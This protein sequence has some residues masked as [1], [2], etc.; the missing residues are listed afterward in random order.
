M[1]KGRVAARKRSSL[2]PAAMVVLMV[3]IVVGKVP[4]PV[5]RFV[6]LDA[7]MYHTLAA[8]LVASKSPRLHYALREALDQD[9]KLTQANM[10]KVWPAYYDALPNGFSIPVPGAADRALERQRLIDL[11]GGSAAGT[12][13]PS[14]KPRS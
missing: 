14:D 8:V 9:G 3:A 12:A 11:V 13:A 1:D 10:K 4:N 5:D 6:E 7:T 2:I